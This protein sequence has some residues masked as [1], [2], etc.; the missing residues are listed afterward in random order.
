MWHTCAN[1]TEYFPIPLSRLLAKLLLFTSNVS[2]MLFE[3]CNPAEVYYLGLFMD[4]K[5]WNERSHEW[6]NNIAKKGLGGLE[7][8]MPFSIWVPL[9]TAILMQ[10]AIFYYAPQRCYDSSCGAKLPM[11]VAFIVLYL[12]ASV[13]RHGNKHASQVVCTELRWSQ[14][15]TST[16]TW[17]SKSPRTSLMI[18]VSYFDTYRA[19]VHVLCF[20]VQMLIEY[21]ELCNKFTEIFTISFRVWLNCI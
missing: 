3:S 9:A 13:A 14:A 10:L 7:W 19:I 8:S 6:G 5:I 21:L 18:A 15:A 12:H 2:C 16:T 4:W 20:S 17:T 1:F 11:L